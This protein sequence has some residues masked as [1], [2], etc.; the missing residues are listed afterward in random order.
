M[1]TR[2]HDTDIDALAAQLDTSPLRGL[3]PHEAAARLARDGANTLRKEE[4]SSP[5]IILAGQF[6]SLVIWVLIGAAVVSAALGEFV[7]GNGQRSRYPW[8]RADDVGNGKRSGCDETPRG[9]NG[10]RR[11]VRDVTYPVRDSGPLRHV[12]LA[13]GS[14]ARSRKNGRSKPSWFGFC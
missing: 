11:D 3:S 9:T 8:T 13:H 5:W 4:T 6:R 1:L 14:E 12:A 10:R 7:D 2:W